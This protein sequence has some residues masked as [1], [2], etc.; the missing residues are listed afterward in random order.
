MTAGPRTVFITGASGGIGR[1]L[2]LEYARRGADLALL[3]RREPELARLR[4]EITAL[5]RRA[6]IFVADVTDPEQVRLAVHEAQHDLDGL[7]LLLANA[8]VGAY[9]ELAAMPWPDIAAVLDVNVRGTIATV[10]AAVPD[11]LARGRGQVA[12]IS[13]IAG[14]RGVPGGSV[15]GASKAAVSVFLDALRLELAGTPV[16]VTDIQP[17]FVDTG[18]IVRGAYPTPWMW[19]PERAAAVIAD[20]LPEAPAV[21]AFPWQTHVLGT[22]LSHLPRGIFDRLARGVARR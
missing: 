21:L 1:A 12:G 22:V 5:G 16:R 4:A 19:P 15:Y 8:G 11:M 10:A 14:R 9:A 17:G 2:A 20:R 6:R 3:A 18:I 7:E 13:S